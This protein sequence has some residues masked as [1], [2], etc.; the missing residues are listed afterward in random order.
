MDALQLELEIGT[1]IAGIRANTGYSVETIVKR[2][3]AAIWLADLTQPLLERLAVTSADLARA[4]GD[5]AKL[6]EAVVE[7]YSRIGVDDSEN[8]W[9]Y[10]ILRDA[11]AAVDGKQT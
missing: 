11:L 2:E 10:K 4:L 3:H 8:E 9:A 6:R 1:A 5:R 7:A